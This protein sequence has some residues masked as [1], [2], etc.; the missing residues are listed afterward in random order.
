MAKR[1]H[2]KSYRFSI[3][4]TRIFPDG[5]GAINHAGVRHYVNVVDELLA[6]NI[7][8][9]VT[10]YHW[11]LPMVRKATSMQVLTYV[12]SQLCWYDKYYLGMICKLAFIV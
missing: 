3:A 10:L 1:I 5:S 9:A 7:E 11:D 8:P 2:A 4:W 6:P 12:A